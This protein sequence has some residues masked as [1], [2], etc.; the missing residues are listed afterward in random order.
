MNQKSKGR[1][2][3]GT[4]AQSVLP[5]TAKGEAS[6]RIR[7]GQEITCACEEPERIRHVS[8][9]CLRVFVVLFFL[10]LCPL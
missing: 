1:N 3:K 10:F 9:S 2:H 4:K 5:C 8:S 7:T 6:W